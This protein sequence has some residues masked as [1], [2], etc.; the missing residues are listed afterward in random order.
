MQA[1]EQLPASMRFSAWWLWP[2][3]SLTTSLQA[4]LTNVLGGSQWKSCPCWY[5]GK[6]QCCSLRPEQDHRPLLACRSV[7]PLP[8]V[9]REDTQLDVRRLCCSLSIYMPIVFLL[10]VV[11]PQLQ[12]FRFTCFSR[13]PS[14]GVN[15]KNNLCLVPVHTT[16]HH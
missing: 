11:N 15:F 13:L 7:S 10:F 16:L 12:S 8:W 3:S 4:G 2:V 1:G 6:V 5:Q 14:L 9:E